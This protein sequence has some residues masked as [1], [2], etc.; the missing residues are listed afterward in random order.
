MAGDGL[1]EADAGAVAVAEAAAGRLGEV[2][3]FVAAA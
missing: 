1:A 3:V 2:A